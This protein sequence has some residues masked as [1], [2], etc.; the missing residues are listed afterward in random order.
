VSRRERKHSNRAPTHT[1]LRPTRTLKLNVRADAAGRTRP[2]H[3]RSGTP[4]SNTN[5]RSSASRRS[6]PPDTPAAEGSISRRTVCTRAVERLDGVSGVSRSAQA[7]MNDARCVEH[8]GVEFFP[9]RGQSLRPTKAVCSTCLVSSDWALL[10]T[11]PRDSPRRLGW[12][13]RGASGAL[14][15]TT[16]QHR[17]SGRSTS[18]GLRAQPL[19]IRASAELGRLFYEGWTGD[20]ETC[21]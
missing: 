20:R 16:E 2:D 21:S 10:R 15:T 7:W 17:P 4:R 3:T 8:V 9:V 11:P 12:S 1:Q 18:S 13:Q 14:R 6:E 5:R 19:R